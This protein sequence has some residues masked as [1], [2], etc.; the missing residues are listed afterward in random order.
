MVLTS[1]AQ[2]NDTLS[3][4]AVRT[5]A[6][7][8]APVSASA[9]AA[10]GDGHYAD[11]RYSAQG[12]F[13]TPPSALDVTVTLADDVITAVTVT[14]AATNATAREYQSRF[15][16][17]VPDVVV[18]RNIDDVHLTRLAGASDTP[19]CFNDALEKIKQQARS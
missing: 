15:A 13:G 17:A 6:S 18:G 7:A 14:P 16:P 19:K 9:S 12:A 11:G 10:T 4:G 5:S 1:C 2:S 3:A 8:P